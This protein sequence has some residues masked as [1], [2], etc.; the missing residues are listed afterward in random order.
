MLKAGRPKYEAMGRYD[1]YITDRAI[2]ALRKESV[3]TMVSMS[4]I[5]ELAIWKHLDAIDSPNSN[6]P[7]Q[8]LVSQRVI[9]KY[10]DPRK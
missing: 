4:K 9:N 6:K 8:Q 3:D 7:K 10:K 5:V 2:A 1:F